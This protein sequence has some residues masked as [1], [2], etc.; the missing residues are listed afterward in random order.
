MIPR[1]ALA[2]SLMVGLFVA[3][4]VMAEDYDFEFDLGFS[5]LNFDGSQTI[6]T[7]AGTIF[8][9]NEIETDELSLSGTW[10]F[11]G[12]SDDNGPRARATLVD[13]ASSLAIGY[14]QTD[15]TFST[16]LTSTDPA[17]PFPSI[18]SRLE[19]D[20]DTFAADFRYVAKDSGWIGSIGLVTSEATVGAPV[21]SSFDATGWGLGFGKYI[22]ENTTLELQVSQVDADGGSD[23]SAFGVTFEHLG[24]FNDQWQ[25]AV[26]LGYNRV[27]ADGGPDVDTWRAAVSMYPNRDVEFGIAIQDG[28]S[29]L[30]GSDSLGFEGFASW[31]VRP[32]FK[33]SARYRVDDVDYLGTVA[34]ATPPTGGSAD[35][36][37]F[38]INATVR[39]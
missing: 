17:F 29:D 6:T 28:S 13:R 19:A 27:D 35:Q 12:L 26:D 18:D 22:A 15:R 38:G 36:D 25:Y 30:A 8:N 1:I 37:A 23:A 4:P 33:L 2:S 39:F 9:S 5:S 34:F 10:Y 11:N 32:N 16:V 14:S 31:F 3:Q 21:N 7:N 20:D 24:S